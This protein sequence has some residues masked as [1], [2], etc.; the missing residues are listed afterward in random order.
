M[1]DVRNHKRGCLH[2]GCVEK[3]SPKSLAIDS[4]Y[5]RH[6]WTAISALMLPPTN[7]SIYSPPLHFD[8]VSYV[9][10]AHVD[11][12]FCS[13]RRQDPMHSLSVTASISLS[14]GSKS[15]HKTIHKHTH[16]QLDLSASLEAISPKNG[17]L[18]KNPHGFGNLVGTRQKLPF[19]LYHQ[20]LLNSSI[21][22]LLTYR[23]RLARM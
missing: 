14:S 4:D 13:Q 9:L 6:T 12:L 2:L 21:L 18:S 10:H 23:T 19:Y 17:S 3:I 8:F 16:R 22:L 5:A 15:K 1:V 20:T 7:G 11:V